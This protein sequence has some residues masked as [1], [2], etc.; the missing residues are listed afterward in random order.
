M[1]ALLLLLLQLLAVADA[2]AGSSPKLA[3]F[4]SSPATPRSVALTFRPPVVIGRPIAVPCG[5]PSC[6]PHCT[7]CDP[8][9]FTVPVPDQVISLAPN[10]LVA[11]WTSGYPLQAEQL[12]F[13]VSRNGGGSWERA[14]LPP[15]GPAGLADYPWVWTARPG[16]GLLNADAGCNSSAAPGKAVAAMCPRFKCSAS[17]SPAYATL[18]ADASAVAGVSLQA[19][20][21]QVEFRGIPFRL[22]P[23]SGILMSG[24]GDDGGIC[25]LTRP[26]R[27]ADGSLLM[28]SALTPADERCTGPRGAC[29]S[30]VVWRSTDGRTWDFLSVAVNH[31]LFEDPTIGPNEHD[32]SLLS[33]AKTLMLVMRPN[34][35]GKGNGCPEAGGKH[36]WHFYAQVYSKDGGATW[37]Q[38]RMIPGAGAVRPRLLLLESGVLMLSGGRMC[39]EQAKA[40]PLC[41]P[42]AQLS[43]GGAFVW[44]NADGMADADGTHVNGSEW[45]PHCVTA[46]HN[47]GWTGGKSLLFSNATAMQ[48]YTSLVPLGPSSAGVAYSHG[49]AEPASDVIFMMRMDVKT[50]DAGAVDFD[51]RHRPTYHLMPAFGHN[52]DPNGLIYDALHGVYHVGVQRTSKV[53]SGGGGGWYFFTSRDLVS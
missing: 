48:S 22:K 49:W 7:G 42:T 2:A 43:G 28:T 1:A 20:C 26:L 8:G 39:R 23:R 13:A 36:P 25:T 50:D 41:L 21:G 30:I 11:P 19:R 10:V 46:A 35:D 31:T 53:K 45:V 17:A 44:T 47:D 27:L 40:A 32:M 38:P 16:L 37:S 15:S 5:Q 51:K 3:A 4:A 6:Q 24:F 12:A 52:N 34:I 29:M 33:D 14:V 18:V 9:N